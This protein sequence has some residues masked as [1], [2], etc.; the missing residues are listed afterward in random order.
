V[1]EHR[2]ALLGGRLE[3][4][5]DPAVPVLALHGLG[6]PAGGGAVAGYGVGMATALVLSGGGNLGAVQVGM[7]LALSEAGVRPDLL[8]GTSVGAVNGGFAATRFEPEALVG[9]A[10][11]WR[12]LRRSDIYPY[13]PLLGLRGFV[14][15]ADHLVP[16]TGLRALLERHLGFRRLEDA[17][18]PLH[19]VACDVRTGAEVVLSSGPAVPALLASAAIPGVF[20]PVELDGRVLVDGGVVDNTPISTA[21]RLGAD[22]VWVL[23]IGLARGITKL[24]RTALGMYAHGVGIL[25]MHQLRRDVRR[26]AAEVDL[27]LVPAPVALDLSA[28]DFRRS[29]DLIDDAHAATRSWLEAGCPP[30]DVERYGPMG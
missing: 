16:P 15:R 24:P 20:P 3:V 11:V 23:P 19:V 9:L 29:G 18:I 17:P 26:Y 10:D 2:G 4:E 6:I 25:S 7:L 5:D 8:V 27:R 13:R 14:G 21:V 12:G 1:G 22:Q 30:Y 28:V